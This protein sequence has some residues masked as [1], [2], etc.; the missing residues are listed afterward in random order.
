MAEVIPVKMPEEYRN[1]VPQDLRYLSIGLY[2][3]KLL[4]VSCLYA[5]NVFERHAA[6]P[7]NRVDHSRELWRV[8]MP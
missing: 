4:F 7:E 3:S 6:F 8:A 5:P 1:L 2:H